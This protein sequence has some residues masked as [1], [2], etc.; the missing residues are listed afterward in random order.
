MNQ[1]YFIKLL[2]YS[3][4]PSYDRY[5]IY[6]EWGSNGCGSDVINLNRKEID[7]LNEVLELIFKFEKIFKNTVK[8]LLK[9]AKNI[10]RHFGII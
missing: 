8:E 1:L 3:V 2:L 4:D 5:H 6:T 7:L 10:K 9:C